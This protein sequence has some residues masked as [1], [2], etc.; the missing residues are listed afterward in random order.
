[1]CIMI[2]NKVIESMMEYVQDEMLK[3]LQDYY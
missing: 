3:P 1:M 2:D